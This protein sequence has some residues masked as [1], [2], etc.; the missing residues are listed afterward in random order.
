MKAARLHEYGKAPVL[1]DIPVPDFQPDEILLAIIG[2]CLFL[3]IGRD[4]A[5]LDCTA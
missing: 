5:L 1:E 4:V 3:N 2:K